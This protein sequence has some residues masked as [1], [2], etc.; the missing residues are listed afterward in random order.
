MAWNQ[1]E[2]GLGIIG[3]GMGKSTFVAHDHPDLSLKVRAICDINEDRLAKTAEDHNVEISTTDWKELISRPEVDVVGVY[4][5]DALH[6][7]HVIA[8]LEIGKP[9]LVTKLF[10]TS[11]AD[12]CRI[13]KETRERN[14]PLLIG[15]TC[16]FIRNYQIANRLLDE[17]RYGRLL[18]VEATYNHDLRDTFDSTPWRYKMPQDF[19][20]GGLCHPMDL[21]LWTGGRIARVS[22][23][24]HEARRDERYPEGIPDNYIANLR[25]DNGALGRVIGLYSFVHAEG[26][27]YITLT[28]S[29]TEAGSFENKVTWE[30][31][32]EKARVE[33]LAEH[34]LE[35]EGGDG[36]SHRSE[37]LNYM[38][39]LEQCL[40]S[41]TVP[42]PGPL[43]GTRVIAALE[44]VRESA[45]TGQAVDVQWDF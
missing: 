10:T 40:R 42:S 20:F 23:F 13:L 34:A 27:P 11:L 2:I 16:R 6:A 41:G 35:E 5:P 24:S 45:Q 33:S 43:E 36:S 7:E 25:Y 44:A 37:V 19:L 18:Y 17:G 30:P 15:Q 31:V 28:L 21:A 38:T 39:H 29:G 9:V 4:S 26:M 22:A 8:A 32:G 3:L 1:E 14:L 12:A